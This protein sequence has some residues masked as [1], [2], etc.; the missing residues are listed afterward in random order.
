MQQPFGG[1]RTRST[2]S[3]KVCRPLLICPSSFDFAPY[4]IY[5]A[6]STLAP[7]TA[8]RFLLGHSKPSNTLP[9][10]NENLSRKKEVPSYPDPS[11]GGAN[12]H[13]IQIFSCFVALQPAKQPQRRQPLRCR[14]DTVEYEQ[15]IIFTQ[16]TCS[17]FSLAHS[18]IL[19]VVVTY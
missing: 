6:R 16:W 17:P 3:S 9:K 7:V 13:C 18:H 12:A 15:E 10:H 5:G 1:N 19:V 2:V 4:P 11:L 8:A 14:T